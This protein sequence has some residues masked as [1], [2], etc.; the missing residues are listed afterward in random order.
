MRSLIDPA[1]CASG[2]ALT[3]GWMIHLGKA[4]CGHTWPIPRW[5]REGPTLTAPAGIDRD[6][7]VALGWRCGVAGIPAVGQDQPSAGDD[8]SL[9]RV[10]P[11]GVIRRATEPRPAAGNN[12]R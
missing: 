1:Y 4:A 11:G 6:G 10:L 5:N 9:G 7:P 3:E 2:D 8:G 12:E